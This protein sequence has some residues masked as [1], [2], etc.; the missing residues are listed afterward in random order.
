MLR[1]ILYLCIVITLAPAGDSLPEIEAKLTS[2]PP[3]IDGVLEDVWD[4]AA[5]V[6]RFIQRQPEYGALASESTVARLLYDE[7]SLYIAFRCAVRDANKVHASLSE[8]AD[9]VQVFLDTFD[10]D[11]TCY[12][13]SVRASGTE[14]TYRLTDDGRWTETWSGVF[15]SAVKRDSWG[16]TAE[17]AI[18]FKTLRYDAG[19]DRWGID[20][21]RSTIAT[22]ERTFWSSY[23]ETGFRVSRMGALLR[24]RPPAPA[25]HVE[26]Y[27][28]ALMRLEQ[29]GLV[30]PKPWVGLDLSWMPAPTASLQVTTFPDYAEIEADPYRVNM[31]RYELSLTEQ[32]PFFVEAQETFGTGFQPLQLFYS[33]RIG[34]PLP[35]NRV[36]PIWVGT[37]FTGRFGP[38]SAGGLGALTGRSV[39]KY[40]GEERIEPMSYYSVFALRR[41]L[42]ANSEAGLLYVGKDNSF[43]HNH[44]LGL[45]GVLRLDPFCAKLFG[46]SS[47]RGDS[48][49]LG[50]ATNFEWRS[51]KFTSYLSAKLL[52]SLFDVNGTGYIAWRGRSVYLSAGPAFYNSGPI[53]QG[54][55]LFFIGGEQ[56]WDE[57]GLSRGL[58]LDGS[59]SFRNR[60]Y[61]SAGAGADRK[62]EMDS[63]Y[64][65]TS[66]SLHAC[67]DYSKPLQLYAGMD[68]QSWTYNY[69]R[70]G[71]APNAS[72]EGTLWARV[73]DHLGLGMTARPVVEFR[74]GYELKPTEDITIVLEPEANVTFTPKM[75]LTLRGEMVCGYD[76]DGHQPYRSYRAGVMYAWTFRPRSTM[77]LAFDQSADNSTGTLSLASRT[78]VAKLR[79]LLVF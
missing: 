62:W 13:F 6:T 30:R 23:Q 60:S 27:P 66:A 54:N 52:D 20:F 65:T 36:V 2:R 43:F 74:P 22:N 38:W 8:T 39:Y 48:L 53:Q 7:K 46:A 31:T 58:R 70:A 59:A 41:E 61:V 49:G 26:A 17:M 57:P 21:S 34:K 1:N 64:W 40:A 10:D 71:F 33:R 78:V 44:A 79:Y 42:L 9:A 3:K 63:L 18:P 50:L 47:R 75:K 29:E 4:D 68:W 32:R 28:V 12:A 77:Y 24:I 67:T 19:N 51:R 35:G 15:Q 25:L 73:G 55:L 69:R 11:A 76:P 56:S 72:A 5:M 45:D 37:K 14:M 16:W